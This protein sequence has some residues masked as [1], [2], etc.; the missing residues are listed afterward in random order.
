MGFG[1][2]NI[3]SV[4]ATLWIGLLAIQINHFLRFSKSEFTAASRPVIEFAEAVR[5]VSSANN[6]GLV[7]FRH[8][9]KSLMYNKKYNDPKIE[10]SFL[11]GTFVS[12]RE[13]RF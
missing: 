13:I 9:G 4:L 2:I 5:F 3:N 8:W 11:F 7:L 12:V 1:P 6:P 10:P